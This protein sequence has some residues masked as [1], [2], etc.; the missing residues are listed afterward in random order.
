VEEEKNKSEKVTC[1]PCVEP[2]QRSVCKLVDP[3]HRGECL[4]R[5][6]EEPPE[7]F[8]KWLKSLNVS[9]EQ[10]LKALEEGLEDSGEA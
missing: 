5:F 8:I 3:E 2:I 9:T 4:R 6:M 1:P 10:F 7:D